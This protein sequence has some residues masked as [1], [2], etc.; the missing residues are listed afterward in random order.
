MADSGKLAAPAEVGWLV[1]CL[2]P[3]GAS[4]HSLVRTACGLTA[5]TWHFGFHAVKDSLHGSSHCSHVA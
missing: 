1:Q 3:V 4:I 5:S 2:S